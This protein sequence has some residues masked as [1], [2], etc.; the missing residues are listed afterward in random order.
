MTD[1]SRLDEAITAI[2]QALSS[3]SVA[4]EERLAHDASKLAELQQA[5]ETASNDMPASAIAEDDLRAMKSE[6]HEAMTLL[7]NIQDLP[8][9]SEG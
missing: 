2:E 1:H 3:L 9:A 5:K 6:L 4:V 7:K 8:D